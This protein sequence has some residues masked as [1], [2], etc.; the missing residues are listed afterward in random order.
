MAN[1]GSIQRHIDKGRGIAAKHL[2]P[3]FLAYRVG[4]TSSGDFPG[5][6]ISPIS[7]A[8][9][10]LFRRRMGDSDIEV[11]MRGTT[12]WYT[13]IADMTDFLLGDVFVQDDPPYKPGVSYGAGATILPATDEINAMA[14]AWHP[15]V[16]KSVGARL[17]HLM[18]IYR[19]SN[20]PAVMPDNRQYWK[21][22]FDNDLPLV[23]SNG[24]YS[25]GTPG[26][27][28]AS[29]V[30]VG[31]MSHPRKGE[32]LFDPRIPG[33]EKVRPGH[34]FIYVPPLPG[35]LPREGDALVSAGNAR[36]T[37]TTAFEQ[38]AGVVGYQLICDRKIAQQS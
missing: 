27:D 19:P 33:V 34:W 26:I 35:Y 13:I 20:I 30:P 17:D 2:G 36:Y 8:T 23:L 3:P 24:T 31:V 1:Y 7:G 16:N 22:T 10:P 6:W 37:V 25:F 28:N 11:S 5:G 38:R 15:P 29:R 21:S 4:P 12:V 9:F 14:L 18:T 32:N